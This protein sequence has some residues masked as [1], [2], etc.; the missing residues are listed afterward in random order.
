M[1]HSF[2][3]SPKIV[4]ARWDVQASVQ[5]LVQGLPQRGRHSCLKIRYWP[6]KGSRDHS[7]GAMVSWICPVR[8]PGAP[9]DP[10]FP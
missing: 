7:Q 10:A 4:E 6:G 2:R 1:L 3:R 5:V 8:V 9:E